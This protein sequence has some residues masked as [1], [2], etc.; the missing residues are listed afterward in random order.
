MVGLSV[1]GRAT[2]LSLRV[3]GVVDLAHAQ[4]LFSSRKS[5]KLEE[6]LYVPDSVVVT[7]EM[8]RDE[9]IPAFQRAHSSVGTVSKSFPALEVDVLVDRA[10]LQAIPE[11]L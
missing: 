8:F 9:I 4:P 7:P 1:P 3:G 11:R 6:F 10:G 5:S 2:P